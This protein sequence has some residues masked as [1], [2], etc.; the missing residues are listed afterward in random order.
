MEVYILLR[1]S[2]ICTE[3]Y[4]TVNTQIVESQDGLG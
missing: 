3:Q 1:K 2:L 4:F